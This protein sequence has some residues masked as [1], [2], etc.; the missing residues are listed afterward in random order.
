[1][2]G[3]SKIPIVGQ[4]IDADKALGKMRDTAENGG[5]K[6]AALGA[7]FKSIGK[8]IDKGLT[9]P[10]TIILLLVSAMKE[11]DGG[12]E[13]FARSMNMS[14][15]EAL[16]FRK[17]MDSA[18]GVTKGQMMESIAFINNQLGTSSG[19]T[20][21]M[22]AQFTQLEIHAGMTKEELMGITSLSLANGKTL[23]QN[24]NKSL[25]ALLVYL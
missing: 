8:D 20:K 25:W 1:M 10:L 22:S 17:E 19:L 14:Y 21:E 4:F 3:L 2:K 12:A 6:I 23:K 7:G 5:S 15:G 24:T 16:K 11:L 18:A 9:D 13:K